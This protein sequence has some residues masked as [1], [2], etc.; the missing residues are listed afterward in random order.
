M[1]LEKAWAKVYGSYMRIEGGTTGEALPVLCGAPTYNSPHKK[2]TDKN[3][4]WKVLSE[5]DKNKFI[6]ATEVFSQMSE[7]TSRTVERMG[8]VDVH[9]YSLISCVELEVKLNEPKVRLVK[10]RNPYGL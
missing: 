8:L 2:I 3:G 1:L 10:I 5:A 7:H 9:A 6:I 4:F